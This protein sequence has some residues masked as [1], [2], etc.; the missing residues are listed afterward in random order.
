MKRSSAIYQPVKCW[1]GNQQKVCYMDAETAE[2]AARLVEVEHHLPANSLGAY[3]CEYGEHWHL[4][5]K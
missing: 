1:V 5:N 4:A 2:G 3:K